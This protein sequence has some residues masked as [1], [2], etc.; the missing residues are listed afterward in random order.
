MSTFFPTDKMRISPSLFI[1]LCFIFMPFTVVFAQAPGGVNNGLELWHLTDSLPVSTSGL[2]LDWPDATPGST[3]PASENHSTNNNVYETENNL[4]YNSCVVLNDEWFESNL[5]INNGASETNLNVFTIFKSRDNG[6]IYLWG[7]GKTGR[8]N[9]GRQ[10]YTQKLTDGNGAPAT[11]LGNTQIGGAYIN[12]IYIKEGAGGNPQN[13]K[14]YLNGEDIATIPTEKTIP[15]N[16]NRVLT[17]LLIGK[18]NEDNNPVFNANGNDQIDLAEFIVYSGVI[19]QT[20]RERI[21]S[22]LGI[23]YGITLDHNYQLSTGTSVWNQA[24]HSYNNNIV[25]IARDFDATGANGNGNLQ[26]GRSKSEHAGDFLELSAPAD[27]LNNPG[28]RALLAGHDNGNTNVSVPVAIGNS[29]FRKGLRIER[30]W[31]CEQTGGYSNYD[32]SFN[33]DIFAGNLPSGFKAQNMVLLVSSDPTFNTDVKAYELRNN[34]GFQRARGVGF[35]AATSYFTI[36]HMETATWV[37]TSASNNTTIAGRVDS[38]IDQV[39]GINDMLGLAKTGAAPL[40][41]PATANNSTMNFHPY[42]TFNDGTNQNYIERSYMIGHGRNTSS[43]FLIMRN[44]GTLGAT[45]CLLSYATVGNNGLT[46]YSGN[47]LYITDPS[48][49]R[50]AVNA[51]GGGPAS[52][53]SFANNL[54]AVISHV[55]GSGANNIIGVN[56]TEAVANYKNNAVLRSNGTLIIGQ[57]QDIIGDPNSFTA[58][59]RLEG[60]F[61]ELIMFNERLTTQE[62]NQVRTYLGVKYG[63]LLAHD[64]IASDGSVIWNR[65]TNTDYNRAIG[66]IGRDDVF[67]LDQRKSRSQKTDAIVTIEHAAP[68]AIDTSHLLWGSVL[69]RSG[70]TLAD[71]NIIST[72]GAPNGYQISERHWKVSNPG[73]KVGQVVVSMDIPPSRA[74]NMVGVRLLISSSPNF[75]TGFISAG[76][77]TINGSTVDFNVTLKDGE[78]FTLGF[79]T[80]LFYTNNEAGAPSTF[81]ACAGDSVTFNYRGLPSHPQ[82]VRF[83]SNDPNNPFTYPAAVN[84]VSPLPDTGGTFKGELSFRIPNDAVTGNVFFLDAPN[85]GGVIYNSNAFITIYNPTVDFVPETNPICAVDTIALYGFPKG[86]IFS[87]PTGGVI[88]PSGD[89]LYGPA[90]G[91]SANHDN[92]LD[93]DVIYTYYSQYTNGNPCPEPKIAT[94]TL[95]VRDNRLSDLEYAY[96]VKRNPPAT[97][98]KQLAVTSRTISAVTPNIL[99]YPG[100]FPHTFQ[101]TGTYV[102]PLNVFL[103]NIAQASNPVTFSFDNGGCIAA[104]TNDLDVYSPLSISGAPD[105]LCAEAD[106]FLFF[107]DPSPLNAYSLTTTNGVTI[108]AN[109][110]VGTF[111]IDTNQQSAIDFIDN[112]GGSETFAFY[113]DSLPAGDSVVNLRM[114]YVTTRTSNG[115]VTSFTFDAV[116]QIIIVPRPTIDLGTAIDPVYCTTE[117][118][119]TLR[120]I[121]AFQNSFQTYFTLT[122]Q[123]TFGLYSLTDSLYQDTIFN[124]GAHYDS[125]VPVPTRDLEIQLTYTVSRYGCIDHDTAY[126]VIRAPLRPFFFT[127]PAYCR[128]EAPTQLTGGI[129][130]GGVVRSSVGRFEPALGLNDTLGVFDPTVAMIGKTPITY[131]LTDQFSCQY[132]YTDTLLVREPPQ[133]SMTLDVSRTNTSFCGS[134]TA[135]DMRSVLV[136]GSAIDSIRYFGAGVIDST[137][138]PNSVFVA[139][140]GPLAGTGG[141]FPVWS[142]IT[143]SF[144]CKGYDTLTV[145]VIQAPAIDIDSVFNG[146]TSN[147]G[148]GNINIAEHTYCK[149]AASFIIN[150]N[151]LYRK[152]G[153]PR[154]TISGSGVI[155]IDTTYYYDPSLVPVGIEVD[156]VVYTYTDDVG[157]D[158]TDIAIIKLDSIPV[159]TLTGFGGNTN[160]CPNYPIVQLIGSPDTTS[161]AGSATFAGAGV[162]PNTGTFNPSLAGTGVKL[163]TYEFIDNNNCVS[164]DTVTITVNPLP[165][166]K[167]DGYLSQYCTAGA[168]DTLRSLND[169][170][171][172][173]YRF[174]GSIIIDTIGILRPSADTANNTGTT[175][176]TKT[177]YYAYTDSMNC[178]NVDSVNIFIHPTPEIT[179]SGL[180]SAYCFSDLEDNISVFPSGTLYD[181]DLGFS[182]SA[183][184]ITFDPDQDSAGIK[185]FTYRHLDNNGCADTV[186]A[187]TY[188]YR[189]QPPT[190]ANLDTFYCETNDTI[191]VAGTP[192]GGTFSGSGIW[193]DSTNSAWA[194]IPTK[195]GIGTHV[196]TY[197]IDD[198][199]T[200]YILA[201][202]QA[203]NLVCPADTLLNITVRPLPLPKIIGPA[204][205]SSFCSNDTLQQLIPS[206]YVNTTW[207]TFRDTSNGVNFITVGVPDTVSTNPLIVITYLDTIYY[208]NPGNV[209]DGTHLITYVATDSASGCQDSLEFTLIVDEYTA[210]FF[211]LDSVYC[212]SEDSVLLFGIPTG[213]VFARNGHPIVGNPPGSAPYFYP[214][215]G[216]L[217][218]QFLLTTVYDT[219][220]Y[221]FVDGACEGVDTQVVEINPVPQVS[222]TTTY[223][224]NTYCLG[225]D[226]VWLSTVDTGGI[227]SGSGVPFQSNVFIPDLAGGGHHAITYYYLDSLTGCDNEFIDTLFVYSMPNVDFAVDG[228]CQ[229]DS[230]RFKPNNNILGLTSNS[231]VV[232]S[233]TSVQWVMSP[234]YSVIDTTQSRPIDSLNYLYTTAG[235]YYTQLIVA[236]RLHCIDTQTVRLV[237]SPKVDSFPYEQDFEASG[238][239]WFAESRDSSHSL[240]WEWG[241]DNNPLGVIDD[242]NN[243]IWA[244]QTN[245]GY[246]P[247]E[248]AWVYSPCFDISVLNRPMISLDYWSDTRQQADGS[249]LEYQKADGSW[250]P[251]GQLNRGINWFNTPF[252]AGDP[253]DDTHRVFPL[254]WSGESD[255]WQNG[256]YK[257]DAYRGVNNVVRL[258]LAFASLKNDPMGNYD[259]FAFDNVIVRDRTRNV[260]LETMVHGSYNNMENVND[261]A[262]QLIYHTNLNKDVVM[263][264]YHIENA[265]GNGTGATDA[266]NLHNPSLGNTRAFEYN[267]SPAGRSFIDGLDSSKTYT[268]SRL[269]DADFEQDML[270]TPKFSIEIDTFSHINGNFK[271]VARVTAEGAIPAPSLPDLPPSYRIYT[272]ISE[273]SLSYPN[274]SSYTNEIHAVARENDQYHLNTNQS[275]DNLYTNR[276]WAD[277]ETQ[278]VEFN[279]NHTSSGFIN[280]EPGDFQ[281]VVFIQN[282]DTKEIFQVATTRDVSGYWVGVEPIQAEEELNEIQN[283]VL[284]P[285]PAHDYFNLRFD[286]VL[287]NDYQWKLVDIRGVEVRTGEIQAGNDQ[288]RVEGL[289]CPPGT[290]IMLLYNNNVFVQRKV[291]LG[292]P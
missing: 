152:N 26:Q 195:A 289:N 198:T 193:L 222:F 55:R 125:L 194:F 164:S 5:N 129:L 209:V 138:N 50:T 7:N 151:P 102:T 246:G 28:E 146:N 98:E 279:W 47:S 170:T 70:T 225:G 153:S 234:T 220:T 23:K 116:A 66:G 71:Y 160:Y 257:L 282:I 58:N 186:I 20:N 268:T 2:S 12:H 114:Q 161:S 81:E 38:L 266:F 221:S 94:E 142:V 111:T 206:T 169:T 140:G 258:R 265:S 181:N 277:Q 175:T 196:V 247:E 104:M 27:F 13:S 6:D 285:N 208:F 284:F 174:Y 61:A 250:A 15:T 236:N 46:E 223:A 39:M 238:G 275:T 230:V 17:K 188:V 33:D 92:F 124:P 44:D 292:R 228:G 63:L 137:L 80:D 213:G 115:N 199:L 172:G 31:R 103:G 48:D 248:D 200:G 171:T 190:I 43:T 107:R 202:G 271:I 69:Y 25:G 215:Q 255:S 75:N 62:T 40:T 32:I 122:G 16:P 276:V 165:N 123:D 242:P 184:T 100:G 41:V 239:D 254:G 52:G 288:M 139:P 286:E 73:N 260:L 83:K 109:K 95:T 82:D 60:D 128:N 173:F 261:Y 22:Y 287:E 233:I 133:I 90:A 189:P 68:F 203:A 149:S 88:N 93:I 3:R 76:Q 24:G 157:C 21:T 108:E 141:T 273:D 53:T 42:I 49:V 252:I 256:R 201:N 130:P 270:E 77:G 87:S 72:N 274:G 45:Q 211:S 96:L 158:N 144:G 182:S 136:S 11:Y 57:E 180:D 105:T 204:N 159:V 290:Y 119:D 51:T 132:T 65:T 235:V 131:I 118:P 74:G 56:G 205:N 216:Y 155:L 135:V 79:D 259:G 4:N 232:D 214:N 178:T 156:T 126:T 67:E 120:P 121:P 78:Y 9:D 210:P 187:R 166:P 197:S 14:V 227:F 218:G 226:T 30:I 86:G 240:L 162:N 219:I 283:V 35:S 212:E 263:L 207:S 192:S 85:N 10:A 251:V 99:N 127:K 262:Y 280:Y 224:H 269:S 291:V 244:T 106:S 89:S 245:Q 29:F 34:N 241:I 191:S 113:P 91:W 168:D 281:A 59:Q 18:A 264:Q 267:V 177:I 148:V 8:P 272:V 243:H 36:A 185:V 134:V 97:N 183:N 167:F 64:Y 278:R 143:D 154:G 229:F 237:I 147:Y 176:R 253:G 145:T 112:T 84:V 163:I 54:P 217:N 117:E 179:I 110:V 150:G 37:K 101:F 231:Q 1:S 249:I 19:G